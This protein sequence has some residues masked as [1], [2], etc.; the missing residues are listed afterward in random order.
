MARIF[1]PSEF[2]EKSYIKLTDRKTIHYIIDVLRLKE[3][4]FVEIFDGKGNEYSGLIREAK[5]K[6]VLIEILKKELISKRMRPEIILFQAISKKNSFEFILGK[7]TELGVSEIIPIITERT[8]PDVSKKAELKLRRWQ[9]IIE[10]A[11]GQCG[12][13]DTPRLSKPISFEEAMKAPNEKELILFACIDKNTKRLKDV[14]R[15]KDPERV[16]LFVGP[17][18][19]FSRKEVLRAKEAGYNLVSLGDN[20]LRVETAVINLISIIRYEFS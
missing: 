4:D 12:R 8:V 2:I 3:G 1:I 5:P 11:V 16:I 7:A 6:E 14:L 18:G 15:G 17:E 9:S 13:I 20:I 19:D 10:G